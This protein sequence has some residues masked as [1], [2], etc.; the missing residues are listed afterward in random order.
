MGGCD[1]KRSS[2]LL[3]DPNDLFLTKQKPTMYTG[4]IHTHSL[5]RYLVLILLILVIINAL[6][7]IINKKPFGKTDNLLGLSLFSVTHTQLLVA[8]MLYFVSPHVSFGPDTMKNADLRYWTVEH[9]L[10]MFIAIV[11][12]TLAR[13]TAKKLKDD[14]AKHSRILIFNAIA[15]VLILAAIASSQRGFFSMP[16]SSA[17]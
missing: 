9:S 14:V 10:M 12:I 13:I 8:L 5:L 3:I 17:S 15:L 11:F 16:G 7:G 4:L 6:L 2:G 1:K